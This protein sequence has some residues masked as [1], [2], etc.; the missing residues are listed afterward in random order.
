MASVKQP[1]VFNVFYGD[2]SYLLDREVRRALKWPN[3]SAILLDGSEASEVAIVEAL[4]ESVVDDDLDG[5]VIIVDNAEEV[6]VTGPLVAYAN[7]RD[8][9][10]R[11]SLLVAVYRGAQL[12]KGWID[13]AR[14]GRATPYPK[15]KPWEKDKIKERV[16]GEVEALELKLEEEAFDVLFLL[17]GEQTRSILNEV[18]KAAYLVE[19]GAPISR[20]VVLAVCGRRPV[21]APWSVSEAAF[22]KD[23]K[24]AL[25]AIASLVQE[26]GDEALVPIT[27]ALMKQLETFLILRQMLDQQVSLEA[28]GAALGIHTFRVQKDLP[29]VKKHTLPHLLTQM[30][31]LCDLEVHLKGPATAKRT[32]VELAVLSL[33]A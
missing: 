16:L 2:E 12:S 22:A 4:G 11:S 29:A 1:R 32:R 28:M 21:V 27:A 23:P 7:E 20:E 17:H 14:Q 24:R 9:K 25:R 8:P 30:K 19:K 10:E 15:F 13:V 3:R 6:K 31:N 33:A 18:R 5:T 26:R